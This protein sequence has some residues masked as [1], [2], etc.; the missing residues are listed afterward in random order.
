MPTLALL[1]AGVGSAEPARVEADI[2]AGVATLAGAGLLNRPDRWPPPVPFAGRPLADD[3]RP[4]GA[5]QAM[6]DQQLAFRSSDAALLGEIE[7]Y[8]GL[9]H[10]DGSPTLIFDVEPTPDGGVLLDAAQEWRFPNRSSFLVQLPGVITDFA[11]H[12]L[13]M[14]V[15]HA[16]AALTGDGRLLVL[17][18]LPEAGKSTL[19]AA[20]IQ[21]RCDYLGDELLGVLPDTLEAVGHPTALALDDESREVL[22]LPHT[23]SFTPYVAP[24]LPNSDVTALEGPAGKVTE[25]LLPSYDPEATGFEFELLTPLDALKTLL[26]SVMN[27]DRC[28]ERGWQTLC[29]LVHEVHGSRVTHAGAPELARHLAEHRRQPQIEHEPDTDEE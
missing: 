21:A 15:L 18:G 16:G 17:P 23:G 26:S 29:Q 28:G 6:L 24:H 19:T 14:L 5:T 25:I 27:L 9:T 7:D 4:V 2:R 13:A 1:D 8:L 10:T 12:S 22:G 11:S 20:L 3:G